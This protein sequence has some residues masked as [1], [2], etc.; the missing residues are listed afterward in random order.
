MSWRQAL[1]EEQLLEKEQEGKNVAKMIQIIKDLPKLEN[2]DIEV[3]ENHI[4]LSWKREK[5]LIDIIFNKQG[6]VT[7]QDQSTSFPLNINIGPFMGE[8]LHKFVVTRGRK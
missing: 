1:T 6:D 7:Y 4:H 5:D 2:T 3:D 8:S